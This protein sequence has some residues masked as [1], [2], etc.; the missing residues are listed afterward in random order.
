[1]FVAG[2][3]KR[4]DLLCPQ[5]GNSRENLLLVP[6]KSWRF[7]YSHFEHAHGVQT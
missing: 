6:M 5:F 3:A 4:E 2:G 7:F 1:M